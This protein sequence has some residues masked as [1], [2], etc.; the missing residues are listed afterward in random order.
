MRYSRFGLLLRIK[1]EFSAASPSPESNKLNAS[2]LGFYG[3]FKLLGN[4]SGVLGF[5]DRALVSKFVRNSPQ[6]RISAAR[7]F[8]MA[9]AV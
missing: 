3:I 9:I 1:R 4:T 5:T 2:L 6:A 7:G 8:L